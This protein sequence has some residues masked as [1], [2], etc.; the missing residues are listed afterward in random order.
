MKGLLAGN[1]PRDSLDGSVLLIGIH[2]RPAVSSAKALGLYTLSV[3][4][5]GDV[6][7]IEAADVSRSIRKQ[8]PFKSQG[9]ISENY[10]GEQLLTLAEGLDADRTI[11]TCSMNIDRA[12]IGNSPEKLLALNDKELQLKKARRTGIRVPEYEVVKDHWNAKEAAKAIGYPCVLKPARGAGGKGVVLARSRGDIPFFDEKFLVQEFVKG[13][14]ISTSTLSTKNESMLLSTSAQLL[15]LDLVGQ[16]GFVY[17]GNVVPLTV[18]KKI[19]ENL[20]EISIRLSKSFGVVGWNGID[21]VNKDEPVFMEINP[22]FQGTFECVEKAYN[23]NLLR[24]HILACEGELIE[25]PDPVKTSARLTLYAK[26][27]CL[28]KRDLR[29]LAVDVPL[30]NSIIE[31]QEPVTTV[32]TTGKDGEALNRA[33]VLAKKIYSNYLIPWSG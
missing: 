28:V 26:E 16:S 32:V 19:S 24:A 31:K 14:P 6:D 33:R 9:T 23:L 15:G 12:V 13:S 20:E 1:L 21:F 29:G 27:R 11:L 8:E 4:Y 2:T 22:R 25:R 7:L 30:I 10:S 17:C 18:S 5:F 3:D